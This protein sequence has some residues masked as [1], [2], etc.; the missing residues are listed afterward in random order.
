MILAVSS[1]PGSPQPSGRRRPFLAL[2][3]KTPPS[4]DRYV[5][6]LRAFSICVV[7]LGH[8]L[9]ASVYL[10]DGQVGGVN[11]LHVIPGIWMATWIL[12]VMPLFFFVGGFANLVTLDSL[13]RKGGDYAGFIR[14][15][16]E[17]LMRPT[18]VFLAVWIP[19]AI[20]IDLFSGFT[21]RELEL[22]FELLTRPL[23]FLGVYLI[24]IGLAPAMLRLHRS[25]G[26]K[27]L[28]GLAVGAAVV[29]LIQFGFDVPFVGNFN[30]FFVWLFAHQLG[31]FYAEGS[32]VKLGPKYFA[33]MA[34]GGLA[35]LVLAT[36]AGPYSS[37]MVG[38]VNER[39]NTNPPTICILLLTVWQV[40][41][42]MLLR[43]LFNRRLARNPTWA[44]V[45][46]LNAM[47]MTM[48]LWHQTAVLITVGVLY[49]LGFPQ[50]ETGTARWWLLR[51]VW[52]AALA[53]VLAVLV[54]IFGRFERG[55]KPKR[56]NLEPAGA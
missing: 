24:M 34:A 1:L 30:Y 49:P 18:A 26:L 52:V 48:F 39:S 5:D 12:Q 44:K 51:P 47:I 31:V 46:A 27:A 13:A 17:R 38:L 8:W 35:L 55:V 25:F 23:W 28:A 50:P 56:K 45:I 16:V 53:T 20:L 43:K 10:R 3:E 29:D 42:A 6:F 41:L 11:A 40:G 7:V 32:L 4:R 36:A 14:S 19:I 2:A 9:I 54:L 33:A 37:S 15:R 21:D 22:A